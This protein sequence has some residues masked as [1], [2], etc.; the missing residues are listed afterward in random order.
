VLCPT[1]IK[2]FDK[3]TTLSLVEGQNMMIKISGFSPLAAG[4]WLLAT[5]QKSYCQRQGA[6]YHLT[7]EA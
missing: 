2:W 3:L 1:K 4:H 6:G 5:G 7:S